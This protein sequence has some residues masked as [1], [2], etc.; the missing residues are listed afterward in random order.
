MASTHV[1]KKKVEA[2]TVVA[3]SFQS[4]AKYCISWADYLERLKTG[5]E[6]APN[7]TAAKPS[8]VR[9]SSDFAQAG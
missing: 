8:D 2:P 5:K 9:A 1:I 7:A 6:V 4:A 3:T